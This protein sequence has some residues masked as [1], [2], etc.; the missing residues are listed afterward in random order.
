MRSLLRAASPPRRS[1]GGRCAQPARPDPVGRAGVRVLAW[2][3]RARPAAAGAGHPGL[4]HLLRDAADRAGAGWARRGRGG[5]RVRALRPDGSR[6]RAAAGRAPARADVLD[7]PPRHGLRGASGLQ[8][9]RVIDGVACSRL[10]ERGARDLRHPVPPGGRPHAVRPGGARP[11]PLRHL[12]LRAHVE[13]RV[14]R[15]R[16]DRPDPRTGRR[17]PRDL[18]PVRWRGLVGGGAAGPPRRGRPADVRLRRSRPDAQER[19]PAGRVGVSR[20]VQGAA[21]RGRRRGALPRQAARESRI[22]RR[23]ARPSA[24]SSSGSSRRRP[25][26][27]RAPAT[28]SR[29]RSTRT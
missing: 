10:R 16:A 2:R 20:H 18:R 27:S 1:G 24:P 26:G 25:T 13:R 8:G 29:A 5:R 6:L 11:L 4:G 17:R 23:S 15:R 28:S 3:A 22:P 14:D 19:G 12:R 21:R 7:V 9:A